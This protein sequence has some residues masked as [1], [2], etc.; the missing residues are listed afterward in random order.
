[1][2]RYLWLAGVLLLIL[3]GGCAGPSA[4]GVQ[5]EQTPVTQPTNTPAVAVPE[6]AQELVRTA[7]EA[8]AERLNQAEDTIEL[9]DV[10]SIE[11]PTAAMGCPQPDKMYAQ[12]VTPGYIVRLKTDGTVHEAHVSERGQVALCDLG[13]KETMGM[14]VPSA[15]EPVVKA[16]RRDLASRVDVEVEDVQIVTFESVEWSDSSLGCPEPG[17]MYLQVITPGYRVVFQAKGQTYEYHTDRGNRAVLCEKGASGMTS[18]KLRLREMRDVV[19]KARDDLAQGEGID[20]AAISIVEAVP[21]SQLQ[22]PAPCP[23]ASQLA[24]QSGHDYQ[25]VLQAEGET[26]VYRARGEKV[27][28]CG[29]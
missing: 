13:E 24:G 7:R 19:E 27:V 15:A 8:L 18:Q 9:V 1:M 22:Q 2:Q 14:N 16:A 25:V 4:P 21:I 26:Y 28:R 20:P 11:W 6:E 5:P 29:Q 3:A 12:V 23:E 10:K 17:K